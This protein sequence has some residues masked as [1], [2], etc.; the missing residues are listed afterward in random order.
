[1]TQTTLKI[2][3]MSCGMCEAHI[4]DVIRKEFPDAT[5]VSASHSK[6]TASFVTKEQVD[7]DRLKSAIEATGYHY[8]GYE[9]QPYEKK[10]IFGGLFGKK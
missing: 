9:T 7:P 8:K 6:N 2:E 3:G 5:K 1:M 10:G 4:M